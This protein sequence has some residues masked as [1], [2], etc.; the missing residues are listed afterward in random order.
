MSTA[1]LTPRALLR[2]PLVS[3][4]LPLSVPSP[5]LLLSPLSSDIRLNVENGL[6]TVS[7]EKRDE[8]EDRRDDRG[9]RWLR[10]EISYGTV[11]RAIRLPPD[12]K[13]EEVQARFSDGVL[14]VEVPRRAESQKE[15]EKANVNIQ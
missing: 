5:H 6:L 14:E 2:P 8:N 15:K 1:D 7:A 4:F 9:F 11:T 13:P 3:P 10:R 12:A